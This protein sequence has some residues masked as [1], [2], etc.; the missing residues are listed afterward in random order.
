MLWDSAKEIDYPWMEITTRRA[1]IKNDRELI[2]NYM[3]AH[4]E[5]IALF[6]KDRDFGK[7]KSSRKPWNGRTMNWSTESYDIYSKIF[8]PTPYPNHPG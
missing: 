5:G 6:K 1:A 8:I 4:L 3:K 2:R 7:S